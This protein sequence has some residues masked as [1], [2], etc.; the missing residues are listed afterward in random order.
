MTDDIQGPPRRSFP[1]AVGPNDRGLTDA[2]VA[3]HRLPETA[4]R[5]PAAADA[6]VPAPPPE[7]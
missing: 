4:P 3:A 7:D 1:V 2:A 6:A 5:T